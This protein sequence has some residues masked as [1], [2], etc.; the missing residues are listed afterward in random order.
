MIDFGNSVSVD[1]DTVIADPNTMFLPTYEFATPGLYDKLYDRNSRIFHYGNNTQQ[2]WQDAEYRDYYAIAS[3]FLEIYMEVKY[4]Y[5]KYH[6]FKLTE[7]PQVYQLV[8]ELQML[9]QLAMKPTAQQLCLLQQYRKQLIANETKK[10]ILGQISQLETSLVYADGH[11]TD[12]LKY[13]MKFLQIVSNLFN[14]VIDVDKL[15]TKIIRKAL[16]YQRDPES[17]VVRAVKCTCCSD[18][19]VM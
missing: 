7:Y 17:D 11:V 4:I 15:S 16:K 14:N 10:S 12:T 18:C 3:L 13:K 6:E 8:K 2:L 5:E 19:C 9:S 1:N